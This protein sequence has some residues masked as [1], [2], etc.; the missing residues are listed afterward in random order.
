M[1]KCIRLSRDETG[2][3]HLGL[4]LLAVLVIGVAGLAAYRI[5]SQA[6]NDDPV[7]SSAEQIIDQEFTQAEQQAEKEAKNDEKAV[8]NNQ[9]SEDQ[10]NVQ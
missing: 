2:I 1:K 6:S 5:S 7:A 9:A 3:A 10:D 8:E 4:I